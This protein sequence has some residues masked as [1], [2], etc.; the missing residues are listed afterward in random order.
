MPPRNKIVYNFESILPF[1]QK[2]RQIYQNRN[3]SVIIKEAI[4]LWGFPVSTWVVGSGSTF[5]KEPFLVIFATDL[6]QKPEDVL[7]H[8]TVPV[9]PQTIWVTMECSGANSSTIRVLEFYGVRD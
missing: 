2:F 9:V 1:A 4:N 6:I 7:L 3:L 5:E 8:F